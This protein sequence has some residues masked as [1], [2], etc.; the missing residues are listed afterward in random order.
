[1][2]TGIMVATDQLSDVQPV[3]TPIDEGQIS[4][5]SDGERVTRRGER[6]RVI[7]A[8]AVPAVLYVVFVNH[9]GRNGINWDDWS[10]VPVVDAAIH[11]HLDLGQLWQQHNENRLLFPYLLVAIVG[12]LTHLDTTA[13]V[14]LNAGLFIAGFA[15]LLGS[16]H[17]F[18]GRSIKPV[19]T[20]LLGLLW[21][22]IADTE[23]ALWAFQVAWYVVLL[24]LMAMLYVLGR[25][26][27][28][29]LHLGA[30]LAIAVVASYS[31]IQGLILWPIGLIG[32]LWCLRDRRRPYVALAWVAASA[33]V[34]YLYFR[35]YDFSPNATGGGS[36]GY[37]L[38]HPVQTLGYMLAL[39]GNV[40]PTTAPRTG[41]H[42]LIGA[43]VL[44]AAGLTVVGSIRSVKRSAAL[45]VPLLLITFAL[46]FDLSIAGGR[47]SLG[48]ER[49]ASPRYTM[50]NLLIL[51]AVAVYV[52]SVP[53]A[54]AA[55]GR[56]RFRTRAS[57]LGV[58]MGLVV[59][60]QVAVS[61]A[62][63]L[64]AASAW[65]RRIQAG[66]TIVVHLHRI[67]QP[68]RTLLFD[69]Y[70]FPS[71]SYATHLRW[72]QMV[73]TDQLGELAPGTAAHYRH[74]TPPVP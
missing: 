43:A 31:S 62:V 60:G 21:F 28:S 16:F 44:L 10:F 37:S 17:Q 13:I 18:A 30:A 45:P 66:D 53:P 67:S 22:S 26:R 55:P 24:C 48:I 68:D 14:Y 25:P 51:V 69:G 64:P 41:L 6:A 34:G 35:G 58:G 7:V 20:L 15:L 61:T 32:I 73:Y 12:G 29:G 27:W 47:L 70:V 23:N 65:T 42:E 72:V 59:L 52:F 38:H 39:V 3:P 63:G 71:L 36:S 5:P 9:F 50:A 57:L 54:L 11:H 33:V 19:E 40:F 1:M 49:A 56:S 46:L 74:A 2:H 4:E 8:A